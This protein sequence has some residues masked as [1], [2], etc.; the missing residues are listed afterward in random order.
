MAALST[1]AAVSAIAAS[2]FSSASA[3]TQKAPKAP[4]SPIVPPAPD[5]VAQARATEA[6]LTAERG[7]VSAAPVSDLSNRSA[8]LLTGPSG[9]STNAV[10]SSKTLLGT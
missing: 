6:R 7:R 5:P 9:A 1:I 8:T 3:L 10:T 4:A 2:A